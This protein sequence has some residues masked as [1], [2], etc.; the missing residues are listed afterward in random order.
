MKKYKIL[1]GYAGLGGNSKEWSDKYEITAVELDP[2][3]AKVYQENNPTHKVVAG[4]II[5]YLL[6]HYQEYDIVWLSPPCQA[7]SRMIRSGKNRNPR[8]PSLTLYELKIFLD[9]NFEGRYIIENVKPYYKPVIE[10]TATIGRHL[11]S[12]NFDINENIEVKQ[13]KNFINIGTV[14]GSEQLKEWL[15]INYKGNL[16][17]EKNHDPCQVLRNCVHPKLGLHI[18]NNALSCT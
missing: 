10:P 16:Y 14:A 11:F 6:N 4:C 9:Y 3:I 7:N 18:L 5:E 13:P 15:G 12:A 17:Y 2:K 1:N 8:L